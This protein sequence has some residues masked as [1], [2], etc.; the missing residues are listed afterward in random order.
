LRLD[1]TA[2]LAA[3]TFPAPAKVALAGEPNA[4]G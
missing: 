2:G 1:V 4:L 3:T